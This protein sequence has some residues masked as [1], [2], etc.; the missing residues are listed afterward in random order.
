MNLHT[1]AEAAAE[2]HVSERWLAD[3]ARA[4]EYAHTRIGR[5]R[6]WTDEHLAAIVASGERRA[7]APVPE[8]GITSRSLARQ[9]AS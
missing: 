9:R 5:K 2:L 3:K 4:G 7:V 1:D 6:F 8:V